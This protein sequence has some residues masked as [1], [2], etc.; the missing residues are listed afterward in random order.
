MERLARICLLCFQQKSRHVLFMGS[1]PDGLPESQLPRPVHGSDHEPQLVEHH[2]HHKI[3]RRMQV[4]AGPSPRPRCE[5]KLS[6]ILRQ[7]PRGYPFRPRRRQGGGR[8]S[9]RGHC[10]RTHSER[11]VPL[12][13]RLHAAREPE[14]LQ[15]QDARKPDSRRSIRQFYGHHTR[16]I[17]HG[18]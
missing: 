3:P 17:L 14:R 15:P 10:Q 1:L 11:P 5:R 13:L 6:Q 9:R 18:K 2:R 16:A 8:G 7:Q 12:S 4:N